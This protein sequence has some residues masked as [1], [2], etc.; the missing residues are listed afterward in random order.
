MLQ[1]MKEAHSAD[2]EE[3]T[4]NF[5]VSLVKAEERLEK[6]VEERTDIQLNSKLES[7][8]LKKEL[9]LALTALK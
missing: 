8:D 5:D 7:A 4:I 3:L 1:Q 9:N 6:M 2:L